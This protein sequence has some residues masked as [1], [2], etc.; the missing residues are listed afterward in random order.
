M[1]LPQSVALKTSVFWQRIPSELI[2]FSGILCFPAFLFQQSILI[3]LLEATLF[4]LLALTRRG[5]LRLFP[6]VIM[7]LIVVFFSLLS[8]YGKILL[9]I[10]GD[11]GFAITF[12]ALESGLRRGIRLAGMVFLS[13]LII[14]SKISLPGELGKFAILIFGYID[15]FGKLQL[16]FSPKKFVTSLDQGLVEIW[17]QKMPLDTTTVTKAKA[18]KNSFLYVFILALPCLLYFLLF[19]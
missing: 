7:I 9:R 12:G 10:G 1:K 18:Q 6:T 17:Q 15:A 3:L 2:F 5:K 4:F 11:K 14:S 13:Q 19:L 16:E 8:P